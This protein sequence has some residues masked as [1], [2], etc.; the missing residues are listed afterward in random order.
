MNWTR[1]NNGAWILTIDGE[2]RAT[3]KKEVGVYFPRHCFDR[4]G[5]WWDKI[6]PLAT[7]AEAKQWVSAQRKLKGLVR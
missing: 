4:R 5:V 3:I 2:V 6:T 7:L 1:D